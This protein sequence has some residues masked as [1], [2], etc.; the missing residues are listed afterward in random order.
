[1]SKYHSRKVEYQG[2]VFDSRKEC[3]RYIYLKQLEDE[4]KIKGLERQVK[5]VLIP[6]QREES[7]EVYKKGSKKGS[8]KP[9][10]LIEKECSYYADFTYLK[11]RQ[12]VVEDVKGMKTKDYI[13]KR[14]L[15]LY[16]W[17]IRIREV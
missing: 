11:D 9:G 10:K 6:E 8:Y 1:M 14:K 7:T 13:I 16:I 12:Y 2:L 17:H 15:M 5:F 4:G 3:N